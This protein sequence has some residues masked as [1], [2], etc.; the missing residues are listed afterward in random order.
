MCNA[1]S[2]RACELYVV[3][4]TCEPVGLWTCGPVACELYVVVWTTPNIAGRAQRFHS[5]KLSTAR[6]PL[7]FAQRCQPSD[8][9]LQNSCNHIFLCMK[10]QSIL[11]II[12]LHVSQERHQLLKDVLASALVLSVRDHH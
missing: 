6:K 8:K 4:S 7:M 2:A 10:I 9:L 1:T 5:G 12:G 11:N 3:V